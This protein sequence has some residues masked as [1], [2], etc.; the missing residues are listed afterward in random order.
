MPRFS[1]PTITLHISA[2]DCHR[3]TGAPSPS[4]EAQDLHVEQA[5]QD[6]DGA[7]RD[8]LLVARSGRGTAVGLA[9]EEAPGDNVPGLDA[10]LPI[11]VQPAQRRPR[12]IQRGRTQTSHAVRAQL[13][14]GQVVPGIGTDIIQRLILS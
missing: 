6:C 12:T 9:H 8:E 5:V 13:E 3:D 1:T 10:G 2:K 11:A 14:L 4:R 7:C